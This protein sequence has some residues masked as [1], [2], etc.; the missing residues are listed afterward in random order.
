MIDA[1]RK[2][3]V[4]TGLD[5]LQKLAKAKD[6]PFRLRLHGVERCPCE[7]EQQ[8]DRDDAGDQPHRNVWYP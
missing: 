3:E 4:Q 2:F 1:E 8:N 5:R 7:N 6:Y